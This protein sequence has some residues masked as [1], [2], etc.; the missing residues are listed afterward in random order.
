[1][2]SDEAFSDV[3]APK[4]SRSFF[5]GKEIVRL[6]RR[7]RL[8]LAAACLPSYKCPPNNSNLAGLKII[9]FKHISLSY[10][11]HE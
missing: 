3:F 7:L 9:S 1:M 2:G 11:S 4:I 5:S 8:I 6:Y 10:L